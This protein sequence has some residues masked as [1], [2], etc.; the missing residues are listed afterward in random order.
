MKKAKISF[1]VSNDFN[2]GDCYDCPLYAVLG[3]GMYED[4]EMA[5]Q[6]GYSYRECPIIL[7]VTNNERD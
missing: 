3:E 7:E 2:V 6:L 5:C 4:I 1:E